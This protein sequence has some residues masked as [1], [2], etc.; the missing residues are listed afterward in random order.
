MTNIDY[1]MNQF[2]NQRLARKCVS[3]FIHSFIYFIL[4]RLFVLSFI[5]SYIQAGD[6]GLFPGADS[7]ISYIFSLY[8]YPS[9]STTSVGRGHQMSVPCIGAVLRARKRTRVAVVEFQA[10]LHPISVYPFVSLYTR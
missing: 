7:H 4:R 3:L 2:S 6:P 1:Q 10:S 5:P 8:I 9:Y